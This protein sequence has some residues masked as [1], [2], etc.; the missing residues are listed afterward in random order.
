METILHISVGQGLKNC[1]N[2]KDF[3]S[4]SSGISHISVGLGDLAVYCDQETD[5]GGWLVSALIV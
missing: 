5:G 3:G 1:K 2:L 4:T